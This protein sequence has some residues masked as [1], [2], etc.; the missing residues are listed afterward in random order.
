MISIQILE[1]K[2]FMSKLLSSTMF[3]QYLVNEVSI[4][5]FNTFSIDGSISKTYY[6]EIEKEENPSFSLEF[7][8]WSQLKSYCFEI[9]KGKKTPEKFKF[10][11]QLPV[12]EVSSLLVENDSSLPNS[13]VKTFVLTIKY[14][15]QSV[16]C[17]TAVSYHTFSLD[18]SADSIWDKAFLRFLEQNNIS[19]SILS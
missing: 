19:Y 15:G 14:D 8:S 10:I 3:D 9:I 18:K 17:V 4:T 7:S 2:S 11:F 6:S 12:T 1:L 13:Q 5:T 16:S